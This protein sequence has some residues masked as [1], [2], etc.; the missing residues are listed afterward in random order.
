MEAAGW[1]QQVA[2]LTAER[3]T[4]PSWHWVFW[5]NVPIGVAGL[6]LVSRFLPEGAPR[7]PRPVD[8]A[9]FLLA[10]LA[11]SGLVCGMSV[12][13]LPAL[14]LGYAWATLALGAA[15]G[16]LYL[17]HA[18][19][20]EWPLLDPRMLRHPLFRAGILGG[21]NFRIGVGVIPFCCR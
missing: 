4:Y 18:R 3:T 17:R 12:V 16:A 13:S 21:S 11:F 9:G 5:I 10:S 8:V 14:P 7:V 20:T 1:Q 2:T 6:A 19:R 15:A